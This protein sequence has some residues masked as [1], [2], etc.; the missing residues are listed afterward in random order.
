MKNKELSTKI[1]EVLKDKARLTPQEMVNEIKGSPAPALIQIHGVLRTLKDNGTVIEDVL[2]R[3][4][5]YSIATSSQKE[6][7]T[8]SRNLSKF[9]FDGHSNLSK[10]RLSLAVVQKFVAD[11]DPTM[12]DLKA[13]FPDEIVKPY[14]VVRSDIE[15]LEYSPDPKRKRY[16]SNNE[17]IITLRRG[18][19]Q[20][21]YVTNQWTSER[22]LKFLNIA[23]G[24]LGYKIVK[25]D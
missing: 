22:F 7:T 4:R 17:D 18:K 5:Y 9:S 12:K 15:V 19:I 6:R 20:K 11:T 8:S 25:H 2:D 3:V 23:E 10:G 21:V 1:I 14:G 13:M 16:F 24:R